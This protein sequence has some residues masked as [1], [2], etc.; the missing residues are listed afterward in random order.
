MS[1][2]WSMG[3]DVNGL[4]QVVNVLAKFLPSPKPPRADYSPLYQA[5]PDYTKLSIFNTPS[6]LPLT[7]PV[8][9]IDASP[10]EVERK[11]VATSCLACSRSHLTTIAGA[12]DES[13]RFARDEGVTSPEVLKRIDTAEREINIMERIDLSPDAIQNSPAEEQEFVRPFLPK[14]RELRQNIGQIRSVGQLE[15]AAADAIEVSRDFKSAQM[16][17]GAVPIEESEPTE[18]D[19]V[20]AM[21]TRLRKLQ[22]NGVNLN[23]VIQLAHAVKRGEIS[24]E[25]AREKVKALLPEEG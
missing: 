13:L 7:A 22:A 21:E 6:S 20:K 19:R 1:R 23:P 12:L 11:E 15:K 16:R 3:I 8:R 2:R 18:T 24:L 9:V 17:M 5:L 25:E 10:V 4:V 14:I